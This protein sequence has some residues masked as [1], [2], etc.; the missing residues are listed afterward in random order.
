MTWLLGI[1][2]AVMGLCYR[3][4]RENR[5]AFPLWD[6]YILWHLQG[7]R[8]CY[9]AMSRSL[10][11]NRLALPLRDRLSCGSYGVYMAV[12]GSMWLL[13][14]YVPLFT[15]KSPCIS[16]AR[17]IYLV[18]VTGFTWPLR[19]LCG[20]YG[21]MSRSLR[22]NRLALPLWDGYTSLYVKVW[23]WHKSHIMTWL[24][25][26]DLHTNTLIYHFPIPCTIAH[27]CHLETFVVVS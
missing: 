19:V 21:A 6:R 10:R 7:L 4:C 12:T 15:R 1:Y 22:E 8:G 24:M 27:K 5:L 9:G 2:M 14:G 26:W 11:E 3:V 16:L 23:P 17:Q 13:R 25:R 18:A 20:C